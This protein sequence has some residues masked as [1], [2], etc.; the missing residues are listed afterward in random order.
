MAVPDHAARNITDP[1]RPYVVVAN[2]QSFVDILVISHLPWEMKWL[3]KETFF[4]IPLVGWMM[5]MAG[6]IPLRARRAQ[7]RRA[8]DGRRAAIGSTNGSA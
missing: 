1:R 4:K 5:R 8:G 3:S 2:H 6:D 7:E